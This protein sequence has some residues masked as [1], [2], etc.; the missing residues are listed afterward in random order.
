M[1]D[2]ELLEACLEW[3]KKGPQTDFNND[4][5]VLADYSYSQCVELLQQQGSRLSSAQASGGIGA[6]IAKAPNNIKVPDFLKS[7]S[8]VVIAIFILAPVLII[9]YY[10][11]WTYKWQALPAPPPPPPPPPKDAAK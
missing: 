10:T 7:E 4:V 5:P 9:G 3:S 8:F 1:E 11:K 2:S 6:M